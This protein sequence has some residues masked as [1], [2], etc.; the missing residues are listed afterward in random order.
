M[1]VIGDWHDVNLYNPKRLK[2]NPSAFTRLLSLGNRLFLLHRPMK[3]GE[4]FIGVAV[5][6][7]C[8]DGKGNILLSKR[9]A[10]CRDEFGRWDPGGGALEFGDTVEETLRKEIEQ[11]Y[12]TTILAEEFL[13]FR[14][15]HRTHEGKKTHWIALD[16]KVL[17]DRDKVKNGEPEKFDAVEWFR[18]DA[19]PTPLHSQF[20]YFL[21]KYEG[22]LTP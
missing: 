19:L 4:D 21:K 11:E 9:S 6:F 13:G 20:P 10:N 17:V 15:V 2:H 14:D 3:K 1:G 16:F 12:C 8:H 22:R 7:L 18:L 5:V